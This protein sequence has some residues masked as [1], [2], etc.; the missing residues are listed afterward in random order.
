MSRLNFLSLENRITPNTYSVS[1]LANSGANTLRQ[2]ILDANGHAG[3]DSITFDPLVFDS[4]K[5][6]TLSTGTLSITDDLTITGPSAGVILK[7]TVANNHVIDIY[8]AP[9]G[10]KVVLEN[11]TI[12][13][14][15]ST[16]GFTAGVFGNGQDLTLNNC[17]ITGNT[18]SNGVGGVS[19]DGTLSKAA[20]LTL[21]NCT[22]T[23][24]KGTT[25]GGITSN[26]NTT[27]LVQNCTVARNVSTG[28]TG[29]GIRISGTVGAGGCIIR[30]STITANTAVTAGGG[31]GLSSLTGTAV[32]QNCTITANVLTTALT[33][34]GGGGVGR[35][36]SGTIALT[37]CIVSGNTSSVGPDIGSTGTVTANNC[38]IGDSKGFTFTGSNNLAF[39]PVANLKLGALANNGGPTQTIALLAG[40][41][42]I[43][44]GSNPAP[45]LTTDQRGRP[46]SVGTI[47]IG[48][49]EVQPAAKVSNVVVGD[50]TAQRSIVTQIVV[51]FDS[52]VV[53]SGAAAAAFT[54]VRQ[55]D[56]N[57]VNLAAAVDPTKM[58][59]TLTF[60]GGA[61]DNKSLA[62]GRYTL[63]IL[64]SQIGAEGLDGNGD[65][66]GGDNYQLI[67]SPGT[68]PNLF[69]IFGDA[70]GDGNVSSN[71]FVFFRQSFG[72][73]NDVFDFDGDGI[74]ST[75]DFAQFRQRFGTSI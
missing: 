34:A 71:D 53:F 49:Y 26:T 58:I 17:V 48:A 37:S 47:D 14:G 40:S 5:T 57:A 60:T 29:G 33:N 27:L 22:V 42:C 41:P 2:A 16:G 66:T 1:S 18:A 19:V 23:D 51:T 43:N 32:I 36:N 64:A 67:G 50:G 9:T 74:V 61:V 4:A 28:N 13:G 68:S 65:G 7:N 24:N 46:R 72:G 38:A 3:A 70:D 35:L 20:S 69:R 73:V 12:T 30:N 21:N 52:P 15:G 45:A 25:N 8:Q 63:D 55:G 44:T 31:I 75:S 62:D 6:I 11:L 56:S 39:Q 10:T 54:L 59:V